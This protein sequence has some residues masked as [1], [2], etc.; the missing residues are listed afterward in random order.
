VRVIGH[1][2]AIALCDDAGVMIF[3]FGRQPDGDAGTAQQ[4]VGVGV[5]HQA[6]TGG[7]DSRRG[8]RQEAG[9]GFALQ[10]AEVALPVQLEDLPEGKPR[11]LFDECIEFHERDAEPAGECRPDGALA[12]APQPEQRDAQRAGTDGRRQQIEQGNAE[13]R[14]QGLEPQEGD[15]AGSPFD[16]GEKA[17]R[18]SGTLG[19]GAP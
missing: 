13:S 2:P 3:R 11:R 7:Q 5:G 16:L 8:A 18:H 12:G 17:D 4:G 15:V 14:G 1:R 19:Q 6:A 9:Q 10:P